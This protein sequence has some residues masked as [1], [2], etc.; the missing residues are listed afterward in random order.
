MIDER[1]KV[2]FNLVLSREDV[3]VIPLLRGEK[4]TFTLSLKYAIFFF[5]GN[6]PSFFQDDVDLLHDR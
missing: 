6:M 5:F 2:N 3:W 4:I 1:A